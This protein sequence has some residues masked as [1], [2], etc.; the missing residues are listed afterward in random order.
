[1]FWS[2]TRGGPVLSRCATPYGHLSLRLLQ[3][4]ELV[5]ISMEGGGFGAKAGWP[6]AGYVVITHRSVYLYGVCVALFRAPSQVEE[7]L[8]TR[9]D[10]EI[11]IYITGFNDYDGFKN[12]GHV[13]G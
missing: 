4:K 8:K 10:I 9:P 13:S 6:P 12:A 2:S 3:G 5:I 1:M 11:M 7:L